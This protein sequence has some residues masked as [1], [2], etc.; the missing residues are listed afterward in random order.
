LADT[1]RVRADG[2]ELVVAGHWQGRVECVVRPENL[3]LRRADA[4]QDSVSPG[5]P[6]LRARI[7]RWIDRGIYVRVE[8]ESSRRWLAHVPCDEFARLG[9]TAGVEVD[10]II[11]SK[12]VHVL[13]GR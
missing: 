3:V 8:L 12:G 1:T 10:V 7:A 2:A 13:P 4:R 11:P 5:V 6:A 9:A